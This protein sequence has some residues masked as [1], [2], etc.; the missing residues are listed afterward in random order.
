MRGGSNNTAATAALA[1]PALQCTHRQMHAYNNT[2]VCAVP[3]PHGTLIM[4]HTKQHKHFPIAQ[5]P[6]PNMNTEPKHIVE[7]PSFSLLPDFFLSLRG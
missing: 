4:I 6:Q 5:E 1:H 2:S 7:S 3:H